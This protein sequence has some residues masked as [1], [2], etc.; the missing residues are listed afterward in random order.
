MKLSLNKKSIKQLSK[1]SS[2][3]AKMTPQVAG[4]VQDSL[5]CNSNGVCWTFRGKPHCEIWDDESF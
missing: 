4:G 3:P 5:V 2:L 1:S